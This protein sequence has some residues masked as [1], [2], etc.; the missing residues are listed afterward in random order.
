MKNRM[1]SIKLYAKKAG[2]IVAVS[3]GL[4]SSFVF[5]ASA[6]GFANVGAMLNNSGRIY[7]FQQVSNEVGAMSAACAARKGGAILGGFTS[8]D[9]ASGWNS[10]CRY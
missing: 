1:N 7:G 5:P 6:Q 8:P 2:L 3:A 9:S 4:T 10:V